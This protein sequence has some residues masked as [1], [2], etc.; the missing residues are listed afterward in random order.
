[1]SGSGGTASL[2]LL[3]LQRLQATVDV[4][5]AGHGASAA[6]AA[7]AAGREGEELD[8]GGGGSLKGAFAAMGLPGSFASTARSQRKPRSGGGVRRGVGGGA[9]KSSPRRRR[10][11]S[12]VVVVTE[13][14]DAAPPSVAPPVVAADSGMGY[15]YC[16][17]DGAHQ[18]PFSL[19]HLREWRAGGYF[20]D[21]T[22]AWTTEDGGFESAQAM[23]DRPELALMQPPVPLPPLL[24]DGGNVVG[25]EEEEEEEEEQEEEEEEE[26][27]AEGGADS[28]TSAAAAAALN[29]AATG[30]AI[31]QLAVHAPGAGGT[32]GGAAEPPQV[33]ENFLP[34][35][36]LKYWEQRYRLFSRYDYGIQMDVE[37]FFSVTPERIAV[38]IAE[39]CAA[40]YVAA[41]GGVVI[42]GFAGC[43]GNTIAF[44]RVCAH[45]IAIDNNAARLGMAR[46]NARVYGVA[47]KIQ[48]ILG[49]FTELAPTL[50]AD[51]VFLSPPWG[52]PG[53]KD[54]DVFDVA[55]MM[56]GY[57]GEELFRLAR[58]IT[59]SV[60]YLLPRNVDRNAVALMAGSGARC[61]IERN[62]INKKVKTC[63]AYYGE[64]VLG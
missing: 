14:S 43:G 55:T 64:L 62:R 13:S 16:G 50:K 31:A 10:D 23:G 58:A 48:F 18:G 38:H 51:T 25:R 45:V 1:M 28:G 61:E 30:A 19:A 34:R 8:G 11:R 46:H 49:D 37:G 59:P 21:S 26:E 35:S 41:G 9:Q 54:T 24:V 15:F 29:G 60:A 7:E 56:G 22:L 47:H 53:Y 27:T 3:R 12:G 36:M 5:G 57:D 52:G 63:T 20:P 17:L 44:A 6:A 42:D 2:R 33:R 40:P 39:R 32:S 4:A